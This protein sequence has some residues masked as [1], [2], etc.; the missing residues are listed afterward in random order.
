VSTGTRTYTDVAFGIMPG[1][2]CDLLLGQDFQQLHE[3]VITEHEGE[4]G[5]LIIASKNEVSC[6]RPVADVG[7]AFSQISHSSARPSPSSLVI[8]VTRTKNLLP[9]KPKNG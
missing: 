6:A 4:L 2:C 7:H 1:L 5:D 8:L 9:A 3:R